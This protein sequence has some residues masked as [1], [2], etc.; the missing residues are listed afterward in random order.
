MKWKYEILHLTTKHHQSWISVVCSCSGKF[1][2]ADVVFV[3]FRFVF[4]HLLAFLLRITYIVIM[5]AI[6]LNY[7]RI[8]SSLF[9]HLPR[10]SCCCSNFFVTSMV[11][12]VS[13]S[14]LHGNY[15]I[16]I[17][18]IYF[19]EKF[20]LFNASKR[21]SIGNR[22]TGCRGGAATLLTE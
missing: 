17:F 5:V 2:I 21:F 9:S 15:F 18:Y 11:F 12:Y 1:T 22:G 3:S 14:I 13:L 16:K 19:L 8:V 6:I 10:C 7:E 20:A 4:F